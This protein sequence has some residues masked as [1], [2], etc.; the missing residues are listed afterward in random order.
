MLSD[1]LSFPRRGDDW[2]STLLVGGILTLLGPFVLPAIVLQ[3]YLVRVLDYAAR[4]EREPPSFTQWGSLFVDGL[5]LVVVNLVY[6]LIGAV[7]LVVVLGLFLLPVYTE[8]VPVESGSVPATPATAPPVGGGE[9]G[10]GLVIFLVLLLVAV[11]L[12]VVVAYV[13]PAAL[14]NFAIEDRLGAAFD[15]RTV[16]AGA[17]TRDYFIAWVAAVVVGVVGGLVGSALTAVVVGVFVLFYAQV[18]VYYLVGRGFAAGLAK[19][20]WSEP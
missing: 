2:L 17:F 18:A 19:K 12:A 20:R 14:A 3:G 16:F 5:K 15:V 10:A 6:G 8:A 9:T 4:R 11:L 1:A 13:L 7:P